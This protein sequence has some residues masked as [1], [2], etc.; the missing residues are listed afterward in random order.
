M[1]TPNLPTK[2]CT[3]CG[4]TITWRKKWERSW[5]DV[6][7]CSDACRRRRSSPDDDALEAAI[8]TLLAK[9]PRSSSICPSEAA[10]AVAGDDESAWRP[11]M[12]PARDAARRLAAR[13][14]LEITQNDR[15]VPDASRA[16]GPIRLRSPR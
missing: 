11:L 8:L 12:Q 6:K 5:D 16:K 10:R 4:R 13:G 3:V 9:R 1:P 14:L 15:P 7:F 2:P